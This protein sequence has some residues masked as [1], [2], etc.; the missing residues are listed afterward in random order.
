MV[1]GAGGG[2]DTPARGLYP[3][4]AEALQRQQVSTL[5]VRYRDPRHLHGAVE[6]VRSAA[7]FLTSHGISQVGFVG[8]SLGGAVIIRA[9]AATPET[10]A[11]VALATQTYGADPVSRLNADCATLLL[12]G[13]ADEILPADASRLV[14]GRAHHPKK[15]NLY[16]AAGHGLDE[17]AD[18]VQAAV[19]AWL[20]RYL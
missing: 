10:R 9:A 16:P 18:E 15:L 19:R 1:G 12:H 14:Y 7:E 4:L 20:L 8:H 3:R 17:V 2:W 11:V 13:L 6:D 5:R